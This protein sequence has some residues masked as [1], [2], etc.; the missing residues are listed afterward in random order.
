LVRRAEIAR[1]LA[2]QPALLLLDEPA[3]GLT[4]AEQADLA[5]RLQA[6]AADGVALVVVEHNLPFL[7]GLARRLICLDA[8]KVIAAGAPA[9]VRAD[10]RVRAVYLGEER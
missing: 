5:G 3:A 9:A 7:M 4:P 6:I 2:L 1:A 8:G 10:P